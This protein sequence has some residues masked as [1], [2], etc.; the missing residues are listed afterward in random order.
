MKIR[1]PRCGCF[2]P[3]AVRDED[4]DEFSG[5]D[6]RTKSSRSSTRVHT[7]DL[8]NVSTDTEEA[9]MVDLPPVSIQR[10]R[11]WVS[12]DFFDCASEIGDIEETFPPG[13]LDAALA[14]QEALLF[15]H[16]GDGSSQF[17]DAGK[18]GKVK[19][20]IIPAKGETMQVVKGTASFGVGELTSEEVVDFLTDVEKKG[21]YDSQFAQGNVGSF[22]ALTRGHSVTS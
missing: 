18:S 3:P 9:T 6:R 7:P 5:P 13:M 2:A 1:F 12:D 17:K 15:W 20:A 10:I 4:E 16:T 8:K 21:K 22:G 11:S 19:L 14:A